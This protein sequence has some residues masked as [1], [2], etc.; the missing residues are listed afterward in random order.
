MCIFI[1]VKLILNDF[2]EEIYV[3][4]CLIVDVF[5]GVSFLVFFFEEWILVFEIF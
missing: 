1:I 5:I 4:K 2:N 3:E